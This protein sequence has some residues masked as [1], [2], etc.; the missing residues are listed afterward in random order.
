MLERFVVIKARIEHLQDHTKKRWVRLE[1]GL[2]DQDG[3]R[4]ALRNLVKHKVV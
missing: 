3:S 4:P 1:Y 2:S